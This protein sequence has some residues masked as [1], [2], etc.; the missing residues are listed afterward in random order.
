MID[1]KVWGAVEAWAFRPDGIRAR[2][3]PDGK[4]SQRFGAAL[5]SWT[6]KDRLELP[7]VVVEAG[8]IILPP[9]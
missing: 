7:H 6:V 1:M 9:N 3:L 5:P 8:G 4:R 2:G